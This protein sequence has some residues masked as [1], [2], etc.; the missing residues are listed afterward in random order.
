MVNV[1]HPANRGII[2]YLRGRSPRPAGA[3]PQ[4]PPADITNPYYTL[5]THPDLVERLWDDLGGMLPKDCRWVLYGAPV[6]AHHASGVVFG[7]AGGSHTYALRLPPAERAAAI[8]AGAATIHHY[9]AFPEL[10]IEAAKL[11]L[12][13]F[14]PEWVFGRWLQGE[15]EWCRA[16]FEFAGERR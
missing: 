16:A 8:A 14:G 7:F 10:G 9:P 13:R 5:G 4:A 12:A 6:L 1:G 3:G 11:D 15:E 2:A